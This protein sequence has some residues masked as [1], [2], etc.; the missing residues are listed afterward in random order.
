MRGGPPHQWAPGVQEPGLMQSFC[1]VVSI[2]TLPG[3]L[4]GKCGTVGNH[5][6]L[7]INAGQVTEGGP[8]R[9]NCGDRHY[10]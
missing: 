5:M 9:V 6:E 7:I 8:Q 2:E 3:D 10:H 1:V 4:R